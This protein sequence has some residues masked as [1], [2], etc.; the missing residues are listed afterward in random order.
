MS[1]RIFISVLLGIGVG[2]F[3]LPS[4][5]SSSMGIII[6]IGLMILLFFVGMD[7]GKQKDVFG[8]I[9]KMGLRI[10]LVPIAIIIG[11]VVG[12]ILAGFLIKMP[13]NEAGAVGA[14]LGWY[15]LS[16]TMLLADG[17]VELSALAFLSNV[18]REIIALITIPLIARYVGKLESVSTAGATAMD[19]SLPVISRATDPQTTIIAFITGVI[20]TA[21]VPIILPIILK[22]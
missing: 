22:L 19:T 21:A 9:K 20:C 12:S 5:I 10:L 2:Y 11:S 6:D 13:I 3:F 8:K 14:G 1:L 7:I 16:S 15:T 4:T 17:Y 18:F